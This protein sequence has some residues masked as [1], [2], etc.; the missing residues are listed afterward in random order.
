MGRRNWTRAELIVAFNLYC[1]LPFGQ[2][3]SKNPRVVELARVLAR[4]PVSV[5][6]KLVNCTGLPLAATMR[7]NGMEAC[8][9]VLLNRLPAWPSVATAW[10]LAGAPAAR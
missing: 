3:H 1:K 2:L 9:T 4:T 8:N 6:M 10:R 5:A 7:R